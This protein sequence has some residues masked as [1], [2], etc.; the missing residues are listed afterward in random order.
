MGPREG[1]DGR[2][3]D[4]LARSAE[5]S[6]ATVRTRAGVRSIDVSG[7]RASGVTLDTGEQLRAPRVVSGVHPRTTVLEL[8][9]PSTSPGR[10]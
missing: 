9:A 4:A 2:H 6:G 5:A 3:L 8:V 7:G 10:R 1:P